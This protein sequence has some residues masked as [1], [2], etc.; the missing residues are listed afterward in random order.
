MKYS[1]LPV[2]AQQ[3]KLD[4]VVELAVAVE[5]TLNRWCRRTAVSGALVGPTQD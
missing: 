2:A 5:D 3:G 4:D 1:V